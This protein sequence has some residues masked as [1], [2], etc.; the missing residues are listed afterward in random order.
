M[1][2]LGLRLKTLQSRYLSERIGNSTL[3][4]GNDDAD[5]NHVVHVKSYIE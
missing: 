2:S 3:K 4:K 1:Y 5:A